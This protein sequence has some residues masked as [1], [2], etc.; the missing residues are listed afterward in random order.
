MFSD[1]SRGFLG[2]PLPAQQVVLERLGVTQS[3]ALYE[4]ADDHPLDKVP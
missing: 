1:I 3:V 4:N 2:T